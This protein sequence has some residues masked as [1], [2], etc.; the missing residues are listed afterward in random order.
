MLPNCC[1][2]N[3]RYSHDGKTSQPHLPNTLTYP[4]SI[5]PLAHHDELTSTNPVTKY[6]WSVSLHTL[7]LAPWH[8]SDTEFLCA[9][10]KL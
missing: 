5:V 6:L 9:L 10:E 3:T 1:R 7:F 8:P 4:S 2:A